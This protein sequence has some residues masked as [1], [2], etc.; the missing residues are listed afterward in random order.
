MRAPIIRA[1]FDGELVARF[2]ARVDRS[3]ECWMWLGGRMKRANGSVWYGRFCIGKRVVLAHRFAWAVTHGELD[4]DKVIRHS[5]D[6]P[7]CVRPEHLLSGTQS[8]NLKDMRD[9]GRAHYNSF[10][11]GTGHPN[12]KIDTGR[13]QHIREIRR[14]GLSFAKI[15]AQVG[16]HA[17]TVHDIVRGKTWREASA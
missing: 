10:P 9:R 1:A 11:S 16:L 7:G 17:T 6:N 2:W 8:E 13:A 4:P 14:S 12:A 15:G 3:G 5:C